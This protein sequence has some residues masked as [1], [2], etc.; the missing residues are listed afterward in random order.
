MLAAKSSSL[1][2]NPVI[3]NQRSI[4][5]CVTSLG[6]LFQSFEKMNI[7]LQISR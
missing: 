1:N 6:R 2:R 3:T 4:Q 5:E 7:C